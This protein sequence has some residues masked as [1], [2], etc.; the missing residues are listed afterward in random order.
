[1]VVAVPFTLICAGGVALCSLAMFAL[2]CMA[3]VIGVRDR[4]YL[5]GGVVGVFGCGMGVIHLMIALSMVGV[6]TLA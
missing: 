6:V 2:G 5:L 4:T 3:V 1:M